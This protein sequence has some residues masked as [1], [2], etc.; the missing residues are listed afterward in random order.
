[1]HS[2]SGRYVIT[3]NGEI[4]NYKAIRKDLVD[5]GHEFV[6]TSDTEVMLAAF[7]KWGVEPSLQKFV[8]MFAFGL[9]DRKERQL[10]LVRDRMGEKPLYYG[11]A[12][13]VF[14]FGSQLKALHAH[15][16][17]C[18]EIDRDVLA[19]FFRFNYVPAPYSI[20]KGIRKLLPGAFLRIGFDDVPAGTLNDPLPYW[21]LLDVA[22]DGARKQFRGTD[23]EAV[24]QL[25]DLLRSAVSGQMVSD[26]PLGAFLSGGIDS[27]TIVALMQAQSERP[28]KTF[29]IGFDDVAYNEAFYAKAVA[30]HLG[31]DH[32]EHYVTSREAL[33]V[34]PRLPELYD[35]PFADSSQIPTYLISRVARRHVTVSLSGDGGDEAFCGYNRHVMLDSIWKKIKRVPKPIRIGVAKMLAKIPAS[36]SEVILRRNKTGILSDQVQKLSSILKLDDPEQMY[37]HL[38]YFWDDPTSLV[39]NSSEPPTIL[40][41]R[42]MWPRLENYI[43]RLLYLESMTS[44]PDDMLVKVDRAAMGIS[45]ETRMP[46]LDHRVVEFSYRLPLTVKLRGSVG[47]WILRQVL[48]RYVP[49]NLIERHKSGFDVPIDVWL[50]GPLRDW[51]E[52]LLSEDK[53][54]KQGYL[55]PVLIRRKWAEHLSGKRKW[56]PHL[57]GVLMFQAWIEEN[58]KT[59]PT[60]ISCC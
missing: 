5:L 58:R 25:D 33:D 12:G 11:W 2:A 30:K 21:S 45:L 46:F 28:V 9:W 19:L 35:E 39:L 54:I 29:T 31:T 4:Y 6:G 48:Y 3:Y 24:T 56:H 20:Y 57:W 43:E 44:L 38:L 51:A 32:T 10:F 13:R 60:V 41:N 16:Q 27:S 17:W 55:H 42:N 59:L 40:S 18:G 23:G 47:K 8:G 1:M 22:E 53:L 26:V 49:R 52:G 15:P 36:W 34:I 7:D 50:K 14:L 37:L